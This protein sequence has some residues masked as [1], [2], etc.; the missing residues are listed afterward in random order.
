MFIEIKIL[1]MVIF[2]LVVFMIMRENNSFVLNRKVKLI[3]D[4][5]LII[6]K[7]IFLQHF[8][9]NLIEHHVLEV[10]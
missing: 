5:C 8:N 10:I 4:I 9:L 3:M 7:N 1:Q 2:V 6:L